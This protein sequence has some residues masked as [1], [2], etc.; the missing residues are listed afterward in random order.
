[1]DDFELSHLQFNKFLNICKNNIDEFP[2]SDDIFH[3]H[4]YSPTK[5]KNNN[6]ND[7]QINEENINLNVT[8]KS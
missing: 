7:N 3:T 2:N 1:M 8:Q 6:D 5:T 4:N